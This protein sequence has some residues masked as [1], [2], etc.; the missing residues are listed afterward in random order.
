MSQFP[1]DSS[2]A[3]KFPR[4]RRRLSSD[5]PYKKPR[6][7]AGSMPA[8]R[9][10]PA[11]PPPSE[12]SENED[13][14]PLS[15]I[16]QELALLRRSMETKFSEAERKADS[17]RGE[18]VGKLDANDKAV[19]DLQVAVT[20]VT[21]GVDENQRAIHQVRAEV[22][23]R[24]VELPGKVRAIVQEVLDKS[25]PRPSPP[26]R[27]PPAP[28]QRHRPLREEQPASASSVRDEA[29]DLA[30]RS[31]RLWPVSR[32]GDL[33]TRT[34]EFMVS[35][36]LIDQDY[37]ADLDIQVKRSSGTSRKDR[38]QP[39]PAPRV[40]DEVLVV[41][42]S[43]RE[44]DNVRAHAKNLEK[45]GRGVRLEVPD[46]LWP[47]FRVLQSLAYELKQKNPSFR[48]NILFDDNE[49]DLKMDFSCKTDNWKTVSPSEAKKSLEKCRPTK[50]RRSSVSAADLEQLLGGGNEDGDAE[51]DEEY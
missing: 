45:K 15:S 4:D 44:R 41:F 13:G 46:H 23:R 8:T 27:H 36:L 49:K 30:R 14:L 5:R 50:A 40:K 21:L 39:G 1:E 9:R 7:S 6:T 35:E 34:R 20:D 12:A 26:D 42:L 2:S 19:S 3:G 11:R 16:M 29:Y 38:D 47:S 43:I 25:R 37:A 31:L 28:G 24:E 17:L 32:E 33:A 10:S 18:L 22:E 51:M 48:R